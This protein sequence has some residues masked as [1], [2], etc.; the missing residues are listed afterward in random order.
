MQGTPGMYWLQILEANDFLENA[1]VISV[2]I[3]LGR[4][5]KSL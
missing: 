5:L 3:D 2:S 4:I 1:P